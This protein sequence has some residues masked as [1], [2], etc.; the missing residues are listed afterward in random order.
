LIDVNILK[1]AFMSKPSDI[2]ETADELNNHPMAAVEDRETE[3]DEI[4]RAAQNTLNDGQGGAESAQIDAESKAETLRS[5][6]G[7][8]VR[9]QS[10]STILLTLVAVLLAGLLF[11]LARLVSFF[12]G[13][14]KSGNRQRRR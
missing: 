5:K 10:L 9:R 1:K 14:R 8:Y 6:G 12:S 13:S 7:A 11:F 3:A 2:Q 4:S